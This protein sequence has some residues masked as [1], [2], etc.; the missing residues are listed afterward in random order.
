MSFT[1]AASAP[2]GSL[3][4]RR[5][6][7]STRH[8][9]GYASRAAVRVRCSADYDMLQK[10]SVYSAASGKPV[11]LTSL[12]PATPSN[13]C[14]VAFFTHFGDLSSTEFAEKLLPVLP[15]VR[16]WSCA[17]EAAT[18]LEEGRMAGIV[19]SAARPRVSAPALMLLRMS[20]M[21]ELEQ[22]AC[23]EERWVVYLH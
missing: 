6:G 11:Q 8:R 12:W 7:S 20:L 15:Q 10:Y 1:I 16:H 13:R 23:W 22:A 4:Q 18:G 3:G 14:V 17:L 21:K 5:H 19:Q 9:Q 2:A